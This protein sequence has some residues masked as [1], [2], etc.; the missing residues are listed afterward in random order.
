[1]RV[2]FMGTP[3][4]AISSLEAVYA[5]HEVVAVLTRADKPN[6]RGN[7]IQF[8]PVKEFALAHNIPVFQPENLKDET[9]YA[10][11]A[12]LN[13]D[14]S[15][16]VAYGMM[17]PNNIIDLPKFGTINV[18]GSLLPKYR[19][20]A[21]MQYSVLNGDETAGVTIMY[22]SEALDSGDI[23]LKKE[24]PV[25]VDETFGELH[26]RLAVLGA[27]AL[28][29]AMREI[30]DGTSTRTPQN[31]AEA[32]FAPSIKKEE[33]IID[34]TLPASQVHNRV[35]GLSP[36]PCANTRLPDGKLL[37]VYR[38]EK[39]EGYSGQPGEVVDVIKK[40]GFVVACGEGAVCVVSA[41]PEGKREMPGF[42]LVNGH[43]VKIGDVFSAGNSC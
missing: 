4:Y 31:S 42:E 16:V 7:K 13:P 35:R 25:G 14:I 18:H 9:L 28:V 27:E 34:W 21:P 12:A 36:I 24:I 37:K 33:C 10:E 32:T 6:K 1:M 5:E 22:V 40:K 11:L 15:A 19:G 20:A 39:V 26:D 23:I 41:K 30:A 3:E 8:S 38:T 2:I 17:I 43:Y 29:E